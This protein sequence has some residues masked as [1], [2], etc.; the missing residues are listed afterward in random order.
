MFG[1]VDSKRKY[2]KEGDRMVV[3]RMETGFPSE[4]R[5]NKKGEVETQ[6]GLILVKLHLKD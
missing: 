5:V 6:G 3:T 1:A 2:E 4:L